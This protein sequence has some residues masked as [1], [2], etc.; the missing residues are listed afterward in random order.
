MIGPDLRAIRE[1]H[2]LTQEQLGQ[3]LGYTG[4]RQSVRTTLH[5]YETDKREIPP[6]VVLR[7]IELGWWKPKRQASSLSTAR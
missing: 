6:R 2:G 4:S 3:A 1:A 7:L 5:R